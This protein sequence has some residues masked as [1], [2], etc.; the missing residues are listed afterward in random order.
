MNLNLNN[1]TLAELKALRDSI[2]IELELRGKEQRQKLLQ[3]FRDKAR[4]YGVSLEELLAGQ[5]IKAVRPTGKVA[6]KFANPSNPEQTWT[7]R[8]KKPRW[9][10]ECLAAGN[11]LDE[12]RV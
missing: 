8:G 11:S 3:E 5:K 9:V 4:E 6:A 12:L 2:D 7:G 1:L 10:S